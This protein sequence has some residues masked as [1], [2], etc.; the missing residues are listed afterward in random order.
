MTRLKARCNRCSQMGKAMH[1][2]DS[3]TT[4]VI[5]CS[6]KVMAIRKI[7]TPRTATSLNNNRLHRM[8]TISTVWKVSL[9]LEAR[10]SGVV[11]QTGSSISLPP[12]RLLQARTSQVRLRPLCINHSVA[13][14]WLIVRTGKFKACSHRGEISWAGLIITGPLS[15]VCVPSKLLSSD[16]ARLK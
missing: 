8:L 3:V 16:K 6:T 9:V 11:E 1:R 2:P 7:T 13:T 12:N 4:V 5:I 10:V 15:L 14:R